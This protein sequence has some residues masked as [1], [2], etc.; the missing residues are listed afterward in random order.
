M[1][2]VSTCPGKL[3]LHSTSSMSGWAKYLVDTFLF[4]TVHYQDLACC[5]QWGHWKKCTMQGVW[6]LI[7][8]IHNR[9]ECDTIT[10]NSSDAKT[11]LVLH[12][13]RYQT[14]PWL[15]QVCSL[16]CTPQRIASVGF[17]QFQWRVGLT[18]LNKSMG[19]RHHWKELQTLV[20]TFTILPQFLLICK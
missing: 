18:I 8:N 17:K 6:A 15:C 4:I 5:Q 3:S 19:W 2:E 1:L 13:N 14:R 9:D 7:H 20:A 11:N 16:V 10:C 12:S